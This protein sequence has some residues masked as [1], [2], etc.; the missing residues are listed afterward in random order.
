MTLRPLA[1]AFLISALPNLLTL[2]RSF[3]PR[4]VGK[5]PWR[6]LTFFEIRFGYQEF[7]LFH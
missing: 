1:V 4:L 2:Q 7:D 6:W 3:L 5:K